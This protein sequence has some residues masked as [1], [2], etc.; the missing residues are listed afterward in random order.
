MRFF[1]DRGEISLSKRLT[2]IALDDSGQRMDADHEGSRPRCCACEYPFL[3][4]CS[5]LA[6]I[7][8]RGIGNTP[9]SS[10]TCLLCS[11]SHYVPGHHNAPEPK[12]I[13]R[14]SPGGT[15]RALLHPRQV[16]VSLR[17]IANATA[18]S[19]IE[20][21]LRMCLRV[22]PPDVRVHHPFSPP[23]SIEPA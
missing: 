22:T 6:P 4:I 17:C 19:E 21:F 14:F 9:A 5:G 18:S 20:D 16:P 23:P 12:K 13:W 1:Q 11:G 2:C 3:C 8:F 15:L 10:G 7:T